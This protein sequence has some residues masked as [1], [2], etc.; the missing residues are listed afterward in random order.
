MTGAPGTATK[1]R[2]GMLRAICTK[3]PIIGPPDII[4]G[5]MFTDIGDTMGVLIM[6]DII[7]PDNMSGALFITATTTGIGR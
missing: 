5:I 2:T 1:I 4:P 3:N 7:T 6:G